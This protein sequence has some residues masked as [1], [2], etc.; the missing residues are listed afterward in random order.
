MNMQNRTTSLAIAFLFLLAC[1]ANPVD[2]GTVTGDTSSIDGGGAAV[3]NPFEDYGSTVINS[4]VTPI[5][6]D[7]NNSS[8]TLS[9]FKYA[10]GY[11][12]DPAVKQKVQETL[13]AMSL[14]DEAAQMRG[15]AYGSNRGPQMTDT[16]RGQ[17]TKTIRG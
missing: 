16:Q 15:M 4:I 8:A 1:G 14:A 9:L 3:E 11:Q 6:C 5:V 13:A 2:I 12:V 7:G 10:P 17:D